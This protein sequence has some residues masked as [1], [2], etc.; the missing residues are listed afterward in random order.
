[1]T[2]ELNLPIECRSLE[3]LNAAREDFDFCFAI[4]KHALQK[5]PCFTKL[6]NSSLPDSVETGH[7]DKGTVF[8]DAY[9]TEIVAF[10]DDLYEKI[11]QS[12]NNRQMERTIAML[13]DRTRPFRRLEL[14]APDRAS[15]AIGHIAEMV[16]SLRR[17]DLGRV[18]LVM[19]SGLA[20]RLAFV[21]SLQDEHFWDT[22]QTAFSPCF[23]FMTGQ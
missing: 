18:I 5:N 4:L 20:Q 19:E 8:G 3:A 23:I 9:A 6:S 13:N 12:A 10:E 22:W 17:K 14:M 7:S 11:A 16:T 1:M 15:T 2:T 21:Q